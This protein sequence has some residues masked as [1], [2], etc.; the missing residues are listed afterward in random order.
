MF[1]VLGVGAC[2]IDYVYRLPDYPRP[3]GPSAKLRISSR[4]ISPGGQTATVLCTCAALG[5]RTKYVG[6]VGNDDGGRRVREELMRRGVDLADLVERNGPNPYAVVLLDERQGERIVLWDRDD[7]LR[8]RPDD[9]RPEVIRSARLVHVDDVDAE[10]AL[11]AASLARSAGVRV[12]SDI[13]QVTELTQ[14]LVAAVDVPILAEHVP[15]AL[16]GEHDMERALRAIRRGHAGLLCVTLGAR[17]AMLL[18]GD[19]LYHEPAPRVKVVDTTGAGDVFRGAFIHAL[20]RGDAP[21]DILRFATTAAALS[22]TKPGAI[23]GVPT[24][25]EATKSI[26]AI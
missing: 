26:G 7:G 12:T 18:E 20:L 4:T 17:G 1:D 25:E 19:H 2:S 13:E 15:A 5:L 23:G 21:R 14:R 22:C 6:T 8:L 24:L 10:A 9:I 16:T 11:R 3:D